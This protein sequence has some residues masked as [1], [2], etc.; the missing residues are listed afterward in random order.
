MVRP[1]PFAGGTLNYMGVG[2]DLVLLAIDDRRG[3]VRNGR[4]VALA[5]AAA[6]LIEL[7]AAGCVGLDGGHLVVRGMDGVTKPD[8]ASALTRLADS[9]RPVTV[10]GWIAARGGPMRVRDCVLELAGAGVVQVD[11]PSKSVVGE[12]SMTVHLI[13]RGP[14]EAAVDRFVAVACGTRTN[15]VDEAF[16]ALADALGATRAHLRGLSNRGARSRVSNLTAHRAERPPEPDRTVLAIARA[17]V[18]AMAETARRE[19]D[20]DTSIDIAIPI[21][22]QFGMQP[23]IQTVWNNPNIQ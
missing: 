16:A 3:A 5:L 18:L 19:D 7:A 6:E 1:S 23:G 20:R 14:V 4:Y 22:K 12:R 8:L 13:D 2:A 10:S 15:A 11:D 17:S 21:N 9:K